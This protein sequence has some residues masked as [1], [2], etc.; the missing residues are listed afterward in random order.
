MDLVFYNLYSGN[1]Q[2]GSSELRK[3]LFRIDP[4]INPAYI[5]LDIVFSVSLSIILGT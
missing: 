3:P 5:P 1:P 2:N 4:Y